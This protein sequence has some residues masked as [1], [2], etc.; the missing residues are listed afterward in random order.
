[1]SGII[2]CYTSPSGKQYVG[3]TWEEGRRKWF[4]KSRHSECYALKHAINKYGYDNL[5]YEV[6]HSG[7]VTQEEMD[8]LE[9][10]EIEQRN[11][12]APN[13]YNLNSGGSRGRWSEESKAKASRSHTGKIKSE[14][15]RRKISEAHMGKVF[16]PETRKKM[17]DTHRGKP[18]SEETKEKLSIALKGKTRSPETRARMS[19]AQTGKRMPPVS[20]ARREQIRISNT[21]RKHSPETRAKMSAWQIGKKFSEETKQRISN[22]NKRKVICIE[23]GQVFAGVGDGDKWLGLSKGNVSHAVRG[24]TETAGGYHWEY[25]E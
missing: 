17:G 21:G 24:E 6:L 25:I 20:D 4:H 9:C 7:I 23:T 14:E 8:S 19:A 13:G 1:M 10:L 22:A 5:K 15:T 12:L 18:L 16:S 3:Q 11:T 2:Y